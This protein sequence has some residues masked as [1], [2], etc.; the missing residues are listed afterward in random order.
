VGHAVAS[1]TRR[2]LACTGMLRGMGCLAAFVVLTALPVRQVQADDDSTASTQI[3]FAAAEGSGSGTFGCGQQTR[4]R[5]VSAAVEVRHSERPPDAPEGQGMTL[6]AGAALQGRRE[7][8]TER[9]TEDD[10]GRPLGMSWFEGRGGGHLRIGYRHRYFGVEAGG[11]LWI[12]SGYAT[13]FPEFEASIGARNLIYVLGGVGA[14]QLTTQLTF[15]Y[16]YL[17]LGCVPARG[18]EL[19]ARWGIH[20]EVFHSADRV[21]VIWRLRMS[22]KWAFRGGLALGEFVGQPSLAREASIGFQFSP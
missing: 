5:Y 2:A 19:E 13:V 4:V 3:E 12:D 9:P 7:T 14:A 11:G 15:A 18:L 22:E 20:Q 8:A 6:L 1:G 10:G 21:D 16:P 17:G